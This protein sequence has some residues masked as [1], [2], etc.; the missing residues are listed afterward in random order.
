MNINRAVSYAHRRPTRSHRLLILAS[1]VAAGLSAAV[2]IAPAPASAATPQGCSGAAN[3]PYRIPA[4]M[5]GV[6]VFS[7]GA[8]TP[9]TALLKAPLRSGG[10]YPKG[11]GW[12]ISPGW[13]DA[14]SPGFNR[15]SSPSG[16]DLQV[17]A[18]QRKSPKRVG[19][20]IDGTCIKGCTVH[21][22]VT[23]NGAIK[24]TA[25]V[26]GVLQSFIGGYWSKYDA[27]FG[28]PRKAS[29]TIHATVTWEGGR[30]TPPA[31][32]YQSLPA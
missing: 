2:V 24:A 1:T 28:V 4:A 13:F 14:S 11:W 20:H 18:D 9:G 22:K 21:V 12:D 15:R 3:N 7:H 8:K 31:L 5:A 19:V 27:T 10:R 16:A 23:I 26:R 6:G 25:T 30:F 17:C 29:V 32:T